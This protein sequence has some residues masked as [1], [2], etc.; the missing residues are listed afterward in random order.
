LQPLNNPKGLLSR[1]SRTANAVRLRVAQNTQSQYSCANAPIVKQRPHLFAFAERPS[2]G[3]SLS[4]A[5]SPHVTRISLEAVSYAA[6]F[7]F[8]NS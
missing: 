3:S 2:E 4:Y 5:I 1:L 8:I 7:F 6:L